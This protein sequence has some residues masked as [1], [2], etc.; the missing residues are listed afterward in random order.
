MVIAKKGESL[1][2]FEGACE[3]HIITED[4]GTTGFGYDPYFIPE[5]YHETFAQLGKDVKNTL[6]HR[7]KALKKATQWLKEY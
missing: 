3:G 6:S 2:H 4:R 7:S 5:G 1:A